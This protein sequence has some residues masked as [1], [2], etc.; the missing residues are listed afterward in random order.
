MHRDLKP[1]NILMAED[2]PR[3]IDFGISKAVEETGGLTATG[4]VVGTP[5]FLAPEQAVGSVVTPA[6]DVF[7]LGAVLV[8]AATGRAPF[9]DGPSHALLYRTVH[10]RPDLEGVPGVLTGLLE[11]C[12]AKEPGRRPSAGA[13][14]ER[15]GGEVAGERG[16]RATTVAPAPRTAPAPASA[17]IP[18]PAPDP[19]TADV[20][21]FADAPEAEGEP[22]APGRSVHAARSH[23][24]PAVVL[25]L[26]GGGVVL[27][28]EGVL[29]ALKGGIGPV[30]LS[31]PILTA[32]VV[33]FGWWFRQDSRGR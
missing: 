6:T 17:P 18:G 2:G 31:L 27:A 25:A 22:T 33:G 8:F 29:G 11:S 20:P 3:V 12:L 7:A 30:D 10:D 23:R 21:R 26:L 14:L 9:G 4:V 24:M 32:L 13:L 5:G 19:P 28:I 1:A 16:P 15:L